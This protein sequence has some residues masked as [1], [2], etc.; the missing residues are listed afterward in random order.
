MVDGCF[1]TARCFTGARQAFTT[2]T[3]RGLS[4]IAGKSADHVGEVRGLVGAGTHHVA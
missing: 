3:D 4:R 2:G 1:D